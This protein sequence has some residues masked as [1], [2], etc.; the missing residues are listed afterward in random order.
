MASVAAGRVE[1]VEEERPSPTTRMCDFLAL[2]LRLREGV[3]ARR[4]ERRFGRSLPGALGATLNELVTAD[5]LEWTG[6]RLRIGESSV[7]LTSE[8]LVR[9]DAA[10]AARPRRSGD[11][12]AEARAEGEDLLLPSRG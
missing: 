12:V 10:V 1:R 4:F 11:A 6:E 3:D 5:R 8:I 7:L 2:G 9:L